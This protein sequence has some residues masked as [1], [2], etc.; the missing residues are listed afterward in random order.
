MLLLGAG[1]SR[2]SPRREDRLEGD[3]ANVPLGREKH[4]LSRGGGGDAVERQQGPMWSGKADG[5]SLGPCKKICNKE[6]M[7]N[8][9]PS[10]LQLD[11]LNWL[12]FGHVH[13][14]LY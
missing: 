3:D 12:T 14:Q 6:S 5:P 7:I 4:E 9:S 2:S 10:F 8:D 1:L 13:G 11:V